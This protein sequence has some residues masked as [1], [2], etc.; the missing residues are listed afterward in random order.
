MYALPPHPASPADIEMHDSS[1]VDVPTYLFA[2]AGAAGLPA[3]AAQLVPPTS[4]VDAHSQPAPAP[5]LP[6]GVGAAPGAPAG[7]ELP[8]EEQDEPPINLKEL[9]GQLYGTEVPEVRPVYD[10]FDPDDG[11]S[12][13]EDCPYTVEQ[14]Q[15]VHKCLDA[16]EGRLGDGCAHA[17]GFMDRL[18]DFKHD[19]KH[20]RKPTWP[21]H[22]KLLDQMLYR[23]VDYEDPAGGGS[24]NNQELFHE[25][26]RLYMP[27]EWRLEDGSGR[28]TI[29]P[30]P[31]IGIWPNNRH[32]LLRTSAIAKVARQPGGGSSEQREQAVT[33]GEAPMLDDEGDGPVEMLG[34]E[35]L[36]P[37]TGYFFALE[38]PPSAA[39]RKRMLT[40][41]NDVD[42]CYPP[43]LRRRGNP[44]KP[45]PPVPLKF[46]TG[47]PKVSDEP[48]VDCMAGGGAA[49]CS[50]CDNGG[51]GGEPADGT[52]DDEDVHMCIACDEAEETDEHGGGDADGAKEDEAEAKAADGD[53]A[54]GATHDG[55]GEGEMMEVDDAR[56]EAVVGGDGADDAAADDEGD[57][58]DHEAAVEEEEEEAAEEEEAEEE[59]EEPL[60]HVPMPHDESSA[61]ADLP[62][63][64]GAAGPLH[65]CE[66]VLIY[67]V[68]GGDKKFNLVRGIAT[69]WHA[70]NG[71]DKSGTYEVSIDNE[72][73]RV[74]VA[75]ENLLRTSTY[76]YSTEEG[77]Q[78]FRR[79][80]FD[81]V[82]RM[83][84]GEP[85][86]GDFRVITMPSM[87]CEV[88]PPQF[89]VLAS[90]VPVAK[91]EMLPSGQVKTPS[92]PWVLS[93]PGGEG[94]HH[95]E[96]MRDPRDAL[97]HVGVER[98]WR[99]GGTPL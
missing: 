70:P 46:P 21:L 28:V 93:V 43:G 94:A 4:P 95:C 92:G 81:P 13:D 54:E 59:A 42:L 25:F 78:Q 24:I 30:P 3:E 48:P 84:N 16:L 7:F 60:Q 18:R 6:G 75:P 32:L 82:L 34:N 44:D 61:P 36:I 27:L 11:S 90:L 98:A 86:T 64:K 52:A 41:P 22:Y 45:P 62:K 85:L 29:P 99:G 9:Y 65:E 35:S 66:R 80:M 58:A 10:H 67:D 57:G 8:G 26:V 56:E 37:R 5:V 77:L 53:E 2:E 31:G 38:E 17:Y 79:R 88:M 47:P 55:G 69:C 76:D 15:W 74:R 71:K 40:Q 96:G 83:P 51:G 97:R 63:D 68:K 73:F 39:E 72:H 12:S 87:N 91:E 33:S 49:G 50:C 23:L 89:A 19:K 1:P 14:E 20:G